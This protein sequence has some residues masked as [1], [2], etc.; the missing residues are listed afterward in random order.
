MKQVKKKNLIWFYFCYVLVHAPK[1]TRNTNIKLFFVWKQ[2]YSWK[3]WRN[4][5][6]LKKKID[7]EK[8]S[9]NYIC[10]RAFWE[11]FFLKDGVVGWSCFY[12][13]FVLF[14]CFNIF[15]LFF[16]KENNK[17]LFHIC[18]EI[19]ACN[20]MMM[21]TEENIKNVWHNLHTILN[22]TLYKKII[23]IFFSF[24]RMSIFLYAF[25]AT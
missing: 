9:L 8:K 24:K 12:A 22:N 23:Y 13:L 19:R 15:L 18:K 16:L 3:C 7:D 1:F 11:N 6:L 10:W 20:L 4:L 17:F 14:V 21:T 25:Y 5:L 2:N